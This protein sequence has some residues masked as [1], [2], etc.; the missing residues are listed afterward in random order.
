M[1]SVTDSTQRHQLGVHDMFRIGIGPSSSHTVGPMRAAKAF[2]DELVTK[3]SDQTNLTELKVELY[4]S[5]AA[6]GKGHYTDRATILGLCGY[7]PKTVPTQQLESI[8][9]TLEKTGQINTPVGSVEFTLQENVKFMP[10]IVPD[11]HVNGMKIVAKEHEQTLLNRTYYS[12]G[13]GFV[14]VETEN[15]IYS[16][17]E[18][19]L[20]ERKYPTPYPFTTGDQLLEVCSKTELTIAQVV[21]QNEQS[22]YS[23]QEIDEYLESI[24]K[25]FDDCIKEGCSTSGILPGGLKVKRRSRELFEQLCDRKHIGEECA[26][27]NKLE[28]YGWAGTNADPLRAMDWVNLFALA[29]N[30]ENAAGHRIVTAP[31]NGA[32][33][34]VPAVLGYYKAF[35]PNASIQGCKEFLL[36]ATAIGSIIKVNASIAGAEVGCQGEVGSAAAMAAAGLAQVFGGTPQQVENAA[37]IAMEHNLGLTCDPVGGLV[38]IPCIERNAIAA[39][40]AINAA[41]MALWSDGA[42]NVSLDVVIE[43]MRQTGKDMLSKYKETSEG[44]LA[45]NVVEC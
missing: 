38:Q 11:Y 21:Y 39:V 29:V 43:T 45:V 24:I 5:L 17:D 34:I 41:R 13:G 42:H 14:M 8:L 35:V 27:Y 1:H 6:T 15:E 31:T 2:M 4:G 12:V 18:T 33:G 23:E 26:R 44:G 25:A 40:K 36:A 32:A 3:T 20:R 28:H 30:E 9:E 7:D 10:Q 19:N 22:L 37:E 16:L